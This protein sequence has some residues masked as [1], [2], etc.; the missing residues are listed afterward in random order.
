LR[1]RWCLR[2]LVAGLTIAAVVGFVPVGAG[3]ES[4]HVIA[5][6]DAQASEGEG[7]L[8]FTVTRETA[9]G[10]EISVGYRTADAEA[11]AGADYEAT[12]GTV[13]LPPPRTQRHRGC[14]P[15]RR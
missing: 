3:A 14:S 1:S 9:T 6:A 4:P 8:V 10:R 7:M 11:P 2:V 5:V 13:T 12:S 15:P